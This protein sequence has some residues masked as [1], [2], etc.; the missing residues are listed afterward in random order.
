MS[1]PV[2]KASEVLAR[3]AGEP[4]RRIV[5]SRMI[6]HIDLE[7]S[8]IADYILTQTVMEA[9]KLIGGEETALHVRNHGN[10]VWLQFERMV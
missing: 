10:A 6:S 4:P 3:M 2:K 8:L 9:R 1:E 7:R 5:C